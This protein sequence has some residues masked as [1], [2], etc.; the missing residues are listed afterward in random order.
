MNATGASTAH[1][2]ITRFSYRGA[3]NP[4]ATAAFQGWLV[5][6][7]PLDPRRL[8]FRFAVF[9]IT[10]AASLLGQSSQD[11]DWILIVDCELPERYLSRLKLLVAGRPRTHLHTYEPGQDLGSA[12]W[13]LP[14]VE[15]CCAHILTTQLDDDDALPANFVEM[16]RRGVERQGSHWGMR[17]AASRRSEQWEL[18]VTARAPLGYRCAWHRGNW[19]VSTGLSLL[20][21][22]GPQALTVLS[23]NHQIADFWACTARDDELRAFLVEKWG[24]GPQ[25]AQDATRFI[26]DQLDQFQSRVCTALSASAVP[27]SEAFVDLTADVGPVVVTNHF[28]N[29]QFTRLLEPKKDRVRIEGPQSF[30][31]VPLDFCKFRDSAPLFRKAWASYLRLIRLMLS[32]VRTWRQR[33]R[34]FAWAS[35]RF[36]RV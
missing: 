36:L 10:C 14:Y 13:L 33:A 17:T 21:P 22:M 8:E 18:L 29:D 15:P 27:D 7:D 34:V 23:L 1:A 20:C 9:E 6:D 3:P 16:V 30:P 35:W 32:R 2:V 5:P 28:L 31:N 11:F 19:V 26:A 4:G 12:R 24:L 25:H